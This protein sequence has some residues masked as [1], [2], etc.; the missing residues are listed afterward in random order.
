[1]LL[2]HDCV[3]PVIDTSK[4]STN[5]IGISL[6]T[7][8]LVFWLGSRYL[9]DALDQYSAAE[10]LQLSVTPEQSL[11][12]LAKSLDTERSAIQR[13]LITSQQSEDALAHLQGLAESS[14]QIVQKARQQVDSLLTSISEHKYNKQRN[15]IETIEYLIDDLNENSQRMKFSRS[16]IERQLYRPPSEREEYIRMKLF[17]VHDS[18]INSVNNLRKRIP[19]YP[20]NDYLD[21]LASQELKDSIWNVVDS[22]NQTSILIESFILKDRYYT[23]D[24][25]N[26]DNLAFRLNQQHERIERAFS[27]LTAIVRTKA[28]AGISTQTISDVKNQYDND[29]RPMVKL[30]IL[31]SPTNE[32]IGQHLTRWQSLSDSI[33][34]N[35]QELEETILI[36]T[37]K[38]ADS[39]KRRATARLI[40]TA[41]LVLICLSMA[42]VTFLISRKVQYQSDHDELT[43]IPNRRYFVGALDAFYRKVENSRSEKLVLMSLDLNG[44][45]SIN[46][47]MGHMVGDELLRQVASRLTDHMHEGMVL[48]RMGGDEFAIAY[49]TP[50]AADPFVFAN[51]IR[52]IFNQPFKI[53]EGQVN[54]DTSIGYSTYPDDANSVKELQITADFAMFSA[55]QSGRKT[56]QPFDRELSTVFDNRKALE[57]DL[58][59]A[60]ESN[61]L[62]LHYQPQVNLSSNK[63]DAVEALIRW[64]HP[65]RGMISPGEFISIAEDTGLMPALGSWVLNEACRQAASWKHNFSDPVR[66]AVNISVHQLMQTEFTHEVINTV[67]KHGLTADAI[68]LEITESVVMTDINWIVSSLKTLK[69]FGFRIALDDFGTGYSS[70]S[71]LQNLPLDTLKIDRSF[72]IGLDHDSSSM[73]S[74]TATIASIAKIYGLETVAEGIETEKQ[75]TE[76]RNLGIDVAQGYLYSKPLTECQVI[77]KIKTINQPGTDPLGQSKAA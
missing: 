62:E 54:I 19:S 51:Q 72:I 77:N 65:T 32:R 68:E 25:L 7:S 36:N 38:T 26:V 50:Y 16:L 22:L 58:I 34:R 47:S 60:I 75:L 17:D 20:K 30:L 23:I 4:I 40:Y 6:I 11:F 39:I 41:L 24:T 43:G 59:T 27:D 15:G 73:K 31:G 53:D 9:A 64:H 69:D 14:N 1:M 71:Q 35:T 33:K 21:V 2:P 46:D 42:L 63:V 70:L 18:Y 45:K 3:S 66:I 55:K 56:I 37:A 13:L 74:V 29:Y 10:Q 49:S 52:D 44:F 8:L 76:V 48:A 61:N 67:E 5:L 57:Q 28:I 12:E